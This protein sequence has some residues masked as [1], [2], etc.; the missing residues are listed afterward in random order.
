VVLRAEP[1]EDDLDLLQGHQ[2]FG[3]QA[4]EL[5]EEGVDFLL[6]ID[7]LDHH[8][9]VLGRVEEARGVDE[10]MGSEALEAAEDGRPGE[11]FSRARCTMTS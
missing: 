2:S 9:E 4:V 11:P 5:G 1:I 6:P 8:R 7:D 3:D 10:A